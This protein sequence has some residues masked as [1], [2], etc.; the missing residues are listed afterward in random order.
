M[1][2]FSVL[3]S[4]VRARVGFPEPATGGKDQLDTDRIL[5]YLNNSFD[6]LSDAIYGVKKYVEFT[7]DTANAIAVTKPAT[8]PPTVAAQSPQVGSYP[9]YTVDDARS[10]VLFEN[11]TDPVYKTE[12]RIIPIR[13]FHDPDLQSTFNTTGS[14]YKCFACVTPDRG[15]QLAPITITETNTIGVTYRGTFTRYAVT[16]AEMFVGTSHLDDL[17]R[18]AESN[19]TGNDGLAKTFWVRIDAGDPISPNTFE[20][21]NDGGVTWEATGVAITGSAQTLEDGWT[22]TFGATTGHTSLDTWRWTVTAPLLT[23]FTEQEQ[24]GFPVRA[25][26][27]ECLLDLRDSAAEREYMRAYGPR[28]MG[29]GI[30]G[31]E[32]LAFIERHRTQDLVADWSL[33][34]PYERGIADYL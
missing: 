27:A 21:S 5:E 25:A 10:Y 16:D 1:T 18:N 19:F 30:P 24:R 12:E 7:M 20:W 14:K 6:I 33:A 11:L 22:I 13:A 28:W 23:E 4:L 31:G 17:T 26:I 9:Y 15:F 32:L 3:E 2:N 8:N 34:D 29:E